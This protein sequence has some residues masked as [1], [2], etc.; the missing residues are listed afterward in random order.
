MSVKIGWADG[1][2]SDEGSKINRH[3]HNAEG[4]IIMVSSKQFVLRQTPGLIVLGLLVLFLAAGC[5]TTTTQ[6]KTNIMD[7]SN[8]DRPA[9]QRSGFLVDYSQ[10]KPGGK[11]QAA[12]IYINPNA[13]WSSYNSIIV[14]PVQ[15]WS[16]SESVSVEDQGVLTAYFYNALRENL[17]KDFTLVDKPG[18]GVMRLQVA[19]TEATSSAPVLRSVS[20]IVPQARV[21]NTA[22]SLATG[23]YAFVGSAQ[24]E[25]Q[26]IDSVTGER[27]GA[28]IDKREGGLAI[29]AAAQWK[30][31][32][33]KNVL[34]YWAQKLPARIVAFQKQQ[35]AGE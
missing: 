6:S 20:V 28:A 32:D 5:S 19:I 31:G 14:D 35:K 10:L 33:A 1:W 7:R 15:F 9:I 16:S 3:T 34:D 29:S 23:T 24:T 2:P 4:E 17:Q 12:L 11:D 30:W 25:G 26:I 22:Q 27:L 21:L 8:G 13:K 18:P